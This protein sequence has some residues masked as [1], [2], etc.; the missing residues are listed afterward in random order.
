MAAHTEVTPAAVRWP[1]MTSRVPVTK[2]AT[3]AIKSV[4]W[5]EEAEDGSLLTVPSLEG[6][7]RTS[8]LE[9][10]AGVEAAF[11][12]T[13]GVIWAPLGSRRC[14]D[15]FC[16]PPPHAGRRPASDHTPR[17]NDP[18]NVTPGK[19][20]LVAGAEPSH[21]PTAESPRWMMVNCG[22]TRPRRRLA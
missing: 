21:K 19:S 17:L 15:V 22:G 3:K 7:R 12:Y 2:T 20:M 4:H 16:M 14:T 11:A 5:G 18:A 1:R 10:L 13:R 9:S 6:S 8:P